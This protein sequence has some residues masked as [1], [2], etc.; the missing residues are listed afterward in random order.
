MTKYKVIYH[1][2][3]GTDGEEDDLFN[4]EDEAFEWEATALPAIAPAQK[5]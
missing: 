1:Y 4:S 3:D 2:P 5:S